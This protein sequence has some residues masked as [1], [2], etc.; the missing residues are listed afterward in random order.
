[1]RGK[2]QQ[3]TPGVMFLLDPRDTETVL[4]AGIGKQNHG[5][6]SGLPLSCFMF[7][8]GGKVAGGAMEPSMVDWQFCLS[9]LIPIPSENDIDGGE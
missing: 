1:M 3:V 6:F 5:P 4:S 8:K 9:F 7:L 2:D